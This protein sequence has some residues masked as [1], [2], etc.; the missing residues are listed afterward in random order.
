MSASSARLLDRRRTLQSLMTLSLAGA[1]VQASSSTAHAYNPAGEE[2]RPRYRETE[3]VKAFY[4]T[5]RYETLN[6]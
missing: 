4:R 3:H 1:A 6:R 5:N 2:T